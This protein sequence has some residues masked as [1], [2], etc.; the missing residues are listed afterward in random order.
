MKACAICF[1]RK[2]AALL[3]Q[4]IE[5]MDNWQ[6]DAYTKYNGASSL[7][8]SAL[9][10]VEEPLSQWAR[11][12]MQEKQALIFVGACGIAVRAIAPYLIDKLHDN[13]VLV[14]DE[15]GRYVIPI[16]SGH[17]GQANELALALAYKLEADPVITTATDLHQQFAVDVFAKKNGLYIENKE[18]IAKVSAKILDAEKIVMSIEPGIA[19]DQAA[20]DCIK[21]ISYPPTQP[22]DVLIAKETKDAQAKL[23][24]RPQQYCIGIGC[25]KN[26]DPLEI[27]AL[28][29][30]TLAM[31]NI[32]ASQIFAL[33]S[34]DRKAK[35][36]ALLVWSSQCNVPFLTFS[37]E[38]LRQIEGE[39]SESE[40]VENKVGVGNVCERAALA[41]CDGNGRLIMKKQAV[42]GMTIALAKREWSV[43]F[44][45]N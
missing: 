40:F 3:T 37:T 21:I 44:D 24:L 18:G 36:R 31:Q 28:I 20:P 32:D 29:E 35:E 11:A 45:G 39:F 8:Q 30:R 2:G 34:I 7:N 15:R 14:V 41:A 42:N 5:L 9:A 33:A 16:L 6:I 1:T 17:V 43:R 38:E 13:P 26:K 25:K 12:K 4:I 27:A 23:Y 19:Y 10:Y 22:V